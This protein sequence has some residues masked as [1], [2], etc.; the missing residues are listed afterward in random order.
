[1]AEVCYNIRHFERHG[2]DLE[3]PWSSRQCAV[4]QACGGSLP[5]VWFFVKLPART[6]NHIT[7]LFGKVNLQEQWHPMQL[8][9]VI[10]SSCEKGI[11]PYI[12]YLSSQLLLLVG[13]VGPLTINPS[14]TTQNQKISFPKTYADFGIGFSHTLQVGHIRSK[15]HALLLCLHANI[16]VAATLTEHAKEMCRQGLISLALDRHFHSEINEYTTSMKAH[17]QAVEMHIESSGDIRL[18]V[19]SP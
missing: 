11:L 17:I 6:R 15:L 9:L 4:Y 1:M 8:H 5:T 7:R 12:N 13:C 3:D 14:D 16:N 2:R 19:R 18:L 10:L